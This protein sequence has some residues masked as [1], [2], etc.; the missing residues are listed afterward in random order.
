MSLSVSGTIEKKGFGW[1]TWALVTP[2]GDTY[3][4]KDAPKKL[5]Q[6]G[7]R[8]KVKGLLRDDVM[9]L[10][11]IGPVLEVKSFELV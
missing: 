9:T 6:E 4:L 2:A 1:G 3:E 10:A 11:A 5:L 8:V 7:V